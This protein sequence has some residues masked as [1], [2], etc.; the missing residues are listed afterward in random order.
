[1]ATVGWSKQDETDVKS[2]QESRFTSL[3]GHVLQNT[4]QRTMN[5]ILVLLSH[6]R[7]VN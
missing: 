7:F 1:M 4:R 2:T 5:T 3:T 6:H